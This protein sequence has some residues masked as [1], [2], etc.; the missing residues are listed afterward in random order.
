[1][2]FCESFLYFNS[3]VNLEG[4]K[5]KK[6][7]IQKLSLFDPS[8]ATEEMIDIMTEF[9]RKFNP[10]WDISKHFDIYEAYTILNEN[11]LLKDNF[12]FFKKLVGNSQLLWY[13]H[14]EHK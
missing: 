8:K 14:M 1:M 2:A 5:N 13:M 9:L 3:N 6:R 7:K 10:F 4:K 12:N 11:R